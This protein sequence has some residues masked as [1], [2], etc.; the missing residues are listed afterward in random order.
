[1]STRINGIVFKALLLKKLRINPKCQRRLNKPRMKRIAANFSWQAFGT[2]RVYWYKGEYWVCDG[3][4]RVEAARFLF[5]DCV[6]NGKPIYVHCMVVKGKPGEVFL[7]CNSNVQAVTANDKFWVRWNERNQPEV[8]IVN[9]CRRYGI[10]MDWEGR[11][12]LGG[13]EATAALLGLW[14]ACGNSRKKFND[15]LGILVDC[16]SRP[17]GRHVEAAALSARFI[18]G[19][20]LFI[21]G[22]TYSVSTIKTGLRNTGVEA[23][24]VLRRAARKCKDSGFKRAP[25]CAFVLN[26]LVAAGARKAA[27]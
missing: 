19:F 11:K 3:Q 14:G 15:A 25:C 2:I 20:T 7:E 26:E 16:Y 24:E 8:G 10:R 12:I 18:R 4:H 9:T 27:A 1:M 17:D 22:T 5:P 21:G 23:A 13:V 6:E